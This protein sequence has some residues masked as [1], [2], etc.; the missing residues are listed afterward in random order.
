MKTTI[1]GIIVKN[2]EMVDKNGKP[3]KSASIMPNAIMVHPDMIKK[4]LEGM[5]GMF[6]KNDFQIMSTQEYK[7]Y[8]N[9]TYPDK[10]EK[11]E[12]VQEK[13]VEETE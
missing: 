3:E 13:T 5:N 9:E 7:E 2:P 6:N 1:P 8:L 10:K 11:L 4:L 12:G